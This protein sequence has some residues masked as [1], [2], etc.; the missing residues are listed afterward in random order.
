MA[1]KKYEIPVGPDVDDGMP[2]RV[3]GSTA[4][5]DK[6][7]ILRGYVQGFAQACKRYQPFYFVDGF[8]GPGLDR[9]RDSDR[10]MW[11]S[12]LIAAQARPAFEKVLAMELDPKMVAALQS[13]AAR[14]GNLVV[15]QGDTN[16]SLV[17]FMGAHIPRNRPVLCLLDP[18]KMNLRMET[19]RA[20][21]RF[22]S[23][24]TNR[25]E[26]IILFPSHM[27]VWRMFP[28]QGA[29]A[30]AEGTLTEL[31]GTDAW[32][33][34]W[35]AERQRFISRLQLRERLLDLY[36]QQLRDLGYKHVETREVR[37][38]GR[39]GKKLY[40]LVFATTNDAGRNIM[41]WCF[42]NIY[43]ARRAPTLFD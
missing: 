32:R 22:R 17:S 27:S 11:G 25:T 15:E 12:P 6:L 1:N 26:L 24:Q 18:A 8:A 16:E 39:I 10:L 37:D 23:H 34:P 7:A 43:E 40:D 29:D 14:F 38:R 19:V 9:I 3:A 4:T 36:L 33:D 2:V 31:F 41:K 35:N 28:T 42:S 13:R 20:V 21:A 30:L 5:V